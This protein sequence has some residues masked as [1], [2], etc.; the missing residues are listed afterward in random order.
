MTTQTQ[1]ITTRWSPEFTIFTDA[2]TIGAIRVAGLRHYDGHC[3]ASADTGGFLGRW[4]RI[5]RNKEELGGGLEC[6]V[7]ATFSEIDTTLK[8]CEYRAYQQP[9]H[10][11]IINA[12]VKMA[13]AALMQANADYHKHN[14]ETGP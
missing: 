3:K 2:A 1:K 4:E 7:Q 8:I 5:L 10:Y 9:E 13:R 12:Y 11:E 14:P 6:T